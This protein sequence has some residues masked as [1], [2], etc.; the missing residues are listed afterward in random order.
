MDYNNR[1]CHVCGRKLDILALQ[2]PVVVDVLWD[3][4][5]DTYDLSEYRASRKSPAQ[6]PVYICTDCMERGLNRELCM[7]DLKN[8]PF[9][10]F[11]K[12]L[13]FYRVPRHTVIRIKN[14]MNKILKD[15]TTSYPGQLQRRVDFMNAVLMPFVDP[16]CAFET[17]CNEQHLIRT[18]SQ[19]SNTQLE[20]E[21][22][23]RAEQRDKADNNE[24][25]NP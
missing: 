16:G 17:P 9:N 23:R 19:F 22:K 10:M 3:Q 18:L 4:L 24:R 15:P 25:E 8:V 6:N 1:K 21:L 5:L 11:F 7:S 20:N 13:Y 12:L 14:Y 2:S